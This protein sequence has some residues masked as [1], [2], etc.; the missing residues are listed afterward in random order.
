MHIPLFKKKKRELHTMSE[1]DLITKNPDASLSESFKAARINLMYSLADTEE[2]GKAFLVT[3]AFSAEGKTTTSINLATTLAQTEAKVLLIDS[4][5]RKPRV[6]RYLD[7][8]NKEGLA[9]YL[10][11]FSS[12]DKIV[13]RMEDFNFDYITA[14]SIPPNPAELLSSKKFAALVEELKQHYDYIIFDTPP[15]NAVSDALVLVSAVKNVVFVCRC[16]ISIISEVKKAIA[17]LEFAQSKLLGFIAIDKEGKKIEHY[18]TYSGY[19]YYR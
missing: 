14:G 10:G 12:I 8:K 1:Y 11:G 18:K 13:N 17:A 2:K 3:S 5:L 6:H 7:V 19:Y 4:D 15:V 9:N 16:S